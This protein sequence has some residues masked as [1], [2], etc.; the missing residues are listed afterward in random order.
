MSSGPSPETNSSPSSPLRLSSSSTQIPRLKFRRDSGR[1]GLMCKTCVD[2]KQI[3]DNIDIIDMDLES[4]EKIEF[5]D[6]EGNKH[7]HNENIKIIKYIC[8]NGH[9]WSV[10]ESQNKCWCVGLSKSS[11]LSSSSYSPRRVANK[12]KE[13]KRHSSTNLFRTY[14][15]SSTPPLSESPQYCGILEHLEHLDGLDN[16]KPLKRSPN[17]TMS[18]PH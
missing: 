17:R 9:K 15:G 5:T 2:T 6:L 13:I 14:T 18:T 3:P 4:N 7:S 11:S 1:D 10:R 12:L 8:T 16:G